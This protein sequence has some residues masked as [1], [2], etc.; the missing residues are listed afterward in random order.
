MRGR[1][2]DSGGQLVVPHLARDVQPS[3][4]AAGKSERSM[5]GTQNIFLTNYF[6]GF[7]GK[8][9]FKECLLR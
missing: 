9:V 7:G 2:Q 6:D 3:H 1:V 5:S 8:K 4:F